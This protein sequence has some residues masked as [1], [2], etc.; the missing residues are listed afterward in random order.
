MT[1]KPLNFEVMKACDFDP[2]HAVW[3]LVH[4]PK[5]D[6]MRGTHAGT[7]LVARS[8]DPHANKHTTALYSHASLFGADGELVAESITNPDLCRI[9]TSAIN[10]IGGEPF[11][12]WW[13]F[14]WYDMTCHGK[15]YLERLR[16]AEYKVKEIIRDFPWFAHHLRL[17]PWKL[18]HNMD[19][20]EVACGEH[21]LAGYEGS[22]VRRT[23]GLYKHGRATSKQMTYGRIKNWAHDEIIVDSLEEGRSN[24]NELDSDANGYAKRSTHMENMVPNGMVG[25]FIGRTVKDIVVNGGKKTIPAGTSVRVAAGRMPHDMRRAMFEQPSTVCGSILK[26]QHFPHGVK[27][28]LRFPTA[29]T[30]RPQSD[31]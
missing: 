17:V 19:E 31:M 24:Q 7:G 21:I 1:K 28:K 26:F 8:G 2:D 4:M 30:L 14:D 18:V 3:P 25:A 22:I 9:T 27:D 16:Y 5:I 29:I 20:L 13:I 6:G 12:Q 23:D 10:T 15:H 11:T